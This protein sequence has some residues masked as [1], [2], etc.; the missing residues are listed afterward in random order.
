[1]HRGQPFCAP[2]ST[3]SRAYSKLSHSLASLTMVQSAIWMASM[4]C[5]TPW[6]PVGDFHYAQV[7][8]A[9][10]ADAASGLACSVSARKP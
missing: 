5:A 1:M 2:E 9:D 6:L 7:W 8:V 4:F 3:V 10:Y